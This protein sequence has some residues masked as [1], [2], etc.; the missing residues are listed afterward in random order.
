[1]AELSFSVSGRGSRLSF[2]LF[3]LLFVGLFGQGIVFFGGGMVNGFLSQKKV[4]IQFCL[5]LLNFYRRMESA[6]T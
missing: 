5:I 1:M 2:Y 6:L 3:R 4:G